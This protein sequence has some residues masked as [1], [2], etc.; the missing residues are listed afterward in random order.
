MSNK[1]EVEIIQ[2]NRVDDTCYH[3]MRLCEKTLAQ[4]IN[5]KKMNAK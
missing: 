4:I 1:I 2:S 5:D 3:Q